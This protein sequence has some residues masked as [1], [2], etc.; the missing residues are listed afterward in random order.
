ITFLYTIDKNYIDIIQYIDSHAYY[1]SQQKKDDILNNMHPTP[2]ITYNPY[3][4]EKKKKFKNNPFTTAN[5]EYDGATD[6]FISLNNRRLNYIYDSNRTDKYS[7]KR[8]FKVYER[9]SCCDCLVSSL[10][11]K[12]AEVKNRKLC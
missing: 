9:E 12:A 6:S 11:T 3:L 4:K 1:Y 10:C 8:T 2:L 5:W 7:F